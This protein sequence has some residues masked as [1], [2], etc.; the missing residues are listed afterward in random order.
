MPIKLIP[1][2]FVEEFDLQCKTKDRFVYM[3]IRYSMYGLPQVG[4]LANQLLK[5]RL[6]KYGYYKV[7]YTHG[8]WKQHTRPIQFTLVVDDFGIKHANNKDVEHRTSPKY[9]QRP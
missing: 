1:Q 9:P 4:I 3:E 6:P 2:S 7:P 5:K 8:L